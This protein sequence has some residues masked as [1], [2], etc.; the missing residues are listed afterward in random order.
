M[1]I[2][3][4]ADNSGPIT[5]TIAKNNILMSNGNEI[6]IE[7][8]DQSDINYNFY[9]NTVSVPSFNWFGSNLNFDQWNI[10]TGFDVNSIVADPLFISTDPA[11]PNFLRPALGSPAIDA[12]EFIPGYHCDVS[13]GTTPA[14]CRVWYGSAP[15]IGVY[16]YVS[17]GPLLNCSDLLGNICNPEEDCSAGSFTPAND[18]N[19]CCIGT[20]VS[21]P[22][23][24]AVHNTPEDNFYI[25]NGSSFTYNVTL[26]CLYDDCG[27][28][29]AT[30]DPT[31]G[32][33]NSGSF[34]DNT[35]DDYL[36][37]SSYT[38]PENG[39]IESM[40]AY[41]GGSSF[42][43]RY[44]IYSDSGQLLN[45]SSAFTPVGGYGWRTQQV[46]FPIIAGVDYLLGIYQENGGMYRQWDDG[47]IGQGTLT[48]SGIDFPNLPSSL[49]VFGNTNTALSIYANYTLDTSVKSVVPVG[50][51]SP[52]YTPNQNP[53]TCLNMLKDETCETTW[54]VYANGT[55]GTYEFYVIYDAE[56]S[57]VIDIE[58]Q[59]INIIIGEISSCGVYD[60]NSNEI[61]EES[62]LGS[63]IS[64]WY[65]G[66]IQISELV[67]VWEFWKAGSC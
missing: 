47:I 53:Q 63:A 23:I 20:C 66:Y 39:V 37:L 41:T 27:N 29:T 50:S 25:S 1:R 16:E 30:L 43:V 22:E 18:T 19:Y 21:T 45:S 48:D 59:H 13:G 12:G 61:I 49:P 60:I 2:G 7:R 54:E 46:N 55:N 34:S 17:T 3:G 8:Q 4:C 10:T 11:S 31:F 62:E 9:D 40:T 58:S 24:V 51:G 36:T 6:R 26:Q 42:G 28:V 38:A 65:N 32:N 52:F 64:D 56:N 57:G 35:G 5:G 33:T 15:D 67:N 14:G 44:V